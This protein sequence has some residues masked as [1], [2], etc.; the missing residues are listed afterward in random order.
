MAGHSLPLLYGKAPTQPHG[1]AQKPQAVLAPHPSFP[2]AP[3]PK[4]RQPHIETASSR[5]SVISPPFPSP[6]TSAPAFL[7]D[8]LASFSL[9]VLTQKAVTSQLRSG[10]VQLLNVQPFKVSLLWATPREV[11]PLK[12]LGWEKLEVSNNGPQVYPRAEESR[13]PWLSFPPHLLSPVHVTLRAKGCRKRSWRCSHYREASMVA[14]QHGSHC[15][16][17]CWCALIPP[18]GDICAGLGR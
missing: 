11:L 1:P 13:D 4:N 2:S 9:L 8:Y 18:R 14:G 5:W 7:K 3:V 6:V 16:G 10:S 12:Y 17:M 15:P